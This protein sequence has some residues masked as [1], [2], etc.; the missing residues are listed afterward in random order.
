MG[1]EENERS[2]G[3]ATFLLLQTLSELKVLGAEETMLVTTSG[4]LPAL[5]TFEKA[6]FIPASCVAGRRYWIEL[7]PRDLY[8]PAS[9]GKSK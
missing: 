3:L 2:R 5:R 1:T 7:Q 8:Y 9:S 6:G 4:N